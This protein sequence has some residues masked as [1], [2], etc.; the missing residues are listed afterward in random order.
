MAVLSQPA[1]RLAHVA[2]SALMMAVITWIAFVLHAK[3]FIA[4]FLYLLL[5]LPI[6]IE[7]GL[8]QGTVASIMAIACMD[9]FFTQPLFTLYMSDPQDWVA[10]GAFEAVV[11][12]VSRLAGRLRHQADETAAQRTNVDRLYTMSKDLL[13]F[14]RGEP[15]GEHLVHL[16]VHVFGAGGVALWNADPD[17]CY[18]AGKLQIADEEVRCASLCDSR[19][20]DRSQ[21]KYIRPLSQGSRIVGALCILNGDDICRID[22]RIA[23]AIAS[24]AAIALERERLFLAEGRAEASR[25]GERL[26]SAVLDGLAHAY[27]TPLASIQTAS[28][29]LLEINRLDE[30]EKELATIIQVE[31][32]H[33]ADL[34]TQALQTARL[35][36]E[37]IKL[38]PEPVALKPFL[39]KD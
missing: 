37:H 36:T 30:V 17:K 4:G 38:H 21:G 28:S 33:L 18:T 27:K 7:W 39:Q 16:I 20:D 2:A 1:R 3:A 14:N 12:I 34:T 10:L 29:G 24:L 32:Q 31:A 26:R 8:I 9:L 5:V 22:W 23:D 25:Q 35:E 13:Q 6:T 19:E 11:L 15:V